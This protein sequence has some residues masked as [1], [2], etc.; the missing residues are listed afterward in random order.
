MLTIID[1]R[2]EWTCVLR[3]VKVKELALIQREIELERERAKFE[4]EKKR[5]KEKI[6]QQERRLEQ[7]KLLYDSQL[8]L[9]QKEAIHLSKEWDDLRREQL[10]FDKKMASMD[11]EGIT[12]GMFFLGVQ[13]IMSLKKRYRDLL[14]IYHPDNL[15]GNDDAM[16]FILKEYEG[17]KDKF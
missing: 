17:L 15:C 16:K 5:V 12:S 3:E 1:I 11:K 14:K 2:N 10:I 6:Q 4:A 13:D 9:L 8:K 7:K